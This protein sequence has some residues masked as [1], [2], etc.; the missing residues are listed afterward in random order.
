MNEFNL[1]KGYPIASKPR[2]VSSDLR[3]INHRIV[4]SQRNI[5][6]FDGDRNYGYG[7]FKYDGRWKIIASNIINNYSLENTGRVLQINSEKG[8]LLKDLKDKN[9]QLELYGTETSTYAIS[10][11]MPEIKNNI[12]FSSPNKLPFPDNYF[13]FVIALGV[14]YTVSL[15]EAMKTLREIV[16]VTKKNSFITLASYSN[17]ENYFL[18]KD[19]TLLGT[20]ILKNNEW[21]EVLKSVNYNGD[22][23][24]TNSYTLNLKRK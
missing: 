8:F 15:E 19:W 1:L 17:S 12:I 16:R 11:S 3:T 23:F 10:N 13:D 20:T 7:G 24:F 6:F 9:S 2:I 18:F 14:V 4:A 22:Y 21:I 5:S